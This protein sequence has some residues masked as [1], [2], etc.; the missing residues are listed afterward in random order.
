M[1][2]WGAQSRSVDVDPDA[3][4]EDDEADVEVVVRDRERPAGTKE[5]SRRANDVR[6]GDASLFDFRIFD[7]GLSRLSI[8]CNMASASTSLKNTSVI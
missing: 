3:S 6:A 7:L 8:F 2:D 1:R 5:D 4:V